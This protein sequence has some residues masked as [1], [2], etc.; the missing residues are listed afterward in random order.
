VSG[1][2]SSVK[3]MAIGRLSSLYL[4]RLETEYNE[5]SSSAKIAQKFHEITGGNIETESSSSSK[6]GD[7]SIEDNYKEFY[8]I[9]YDEA[10]DSC[11]SLFFPNYSALEEYLGK[12][13]SF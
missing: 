2:F 10:T 1:D 4:P 5:E 7:T 12:K 11:H 9:K 13:M 6:S 8:L 3:A